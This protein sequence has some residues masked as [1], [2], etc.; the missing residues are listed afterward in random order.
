IAWRRSRMSFRFRNGLLPR[1]SRS[2][3]HALDPS[4][5]HLGRVLPAR[6]KSS[7]EGGDTMKKAMK[8]VLPGVVALVVIAFFVLPGVAFAK[9]SG[10]G[11]TP[12]PPPSNPPCDSDHHNGQPP[13]YGGPN[14]HSL[15]CK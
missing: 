7:A 10:G 6:P 3:P 11:G 1:A 4:D 9:G 8:R 12:N 15:M 5:P 14:I 13:P 2:H